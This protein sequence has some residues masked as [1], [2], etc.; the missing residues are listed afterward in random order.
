L[1]VP[2]GLAAKQLPFDQGEA[3]FLGR[4]RATQS[5]AVHISG[6]SSDAHRAQ[7]DAF[8]I[9]LG[10]WS[11]RREGVCFGGNVRRTGAS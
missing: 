7:E 9:G 1:V 5:G 2:A 3:L 11:Q 4:L 6:V 8:L 10:D